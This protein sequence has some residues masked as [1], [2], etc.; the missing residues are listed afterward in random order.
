[1]SRTVP[2]SYRIGAIA[3]L[4]GLSSH[5]I[6]VWERRYGAV[7][8]VR[9]PGGTREYSAQDLEKLTLLRT[10][11]EA[12]HS[13][14]RIAALEKAELDE[15]LREVQARAPRSVASSDTT[16]AVETLLTH[17]MDL[18]MASAERALLS[19]ASV[20]GPL[21][22]ILDVVAP[23][24]E[25]VGKRCE[26]GEYRIAHERAATAALRTLLGHFLSSHS[27]RP[28]QAIAVAATMSGERHELGALMSSFIAVT[29]GYDVLYTGPDL[30][31]EEIAHIVEKKDAK[32]ILLS[33][34]N[35]YSKETEEQL[36][37]LLAQLPSSVRLIVGGRGQISY[38]HLLP[39]EKRVSCLRELHERLAQDDT[40]LACARTL[41]SKA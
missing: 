16:P 2:A 19:T 20:I 40:N 18:D 9:T 23:L 22:T 17:I 29:R 36:A 28:M 33:I 15:L 24:V 4:T 26:S 11:S 39:P 14:G 34:V 10:L 41:S 6:R 21:A 27:Q 5:T 12:G 25:E 37:K 8:P 3:K 38:S 35:E 31:V 1:M 32:L 13:I 30:P 7:E